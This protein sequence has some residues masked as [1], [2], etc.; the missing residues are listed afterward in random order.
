MA[1]SEPIRVYR[2]RPDNIAKLAFNAI[3]SI[4]YKL[5]I[6]LFTTFMLLSSDVFI[7][8]VLSKFNGAV[9]HRYPTNY[10]VLLQGM[11]LVLAYIIY[12]ALVSLGIA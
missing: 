2:E 8:R 6:L 4:E 3:K 11:F 12:D 1:D 9:D 10:G 5:I 7:N